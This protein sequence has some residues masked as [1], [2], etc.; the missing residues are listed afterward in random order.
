MLF[1]LCIGACYYLAGF[2]KYGRTVADVVILAAISLFIVALAYSTIVSFV[3]THGASAGASPWYMQALLVPV[4]ALIVRGLSRGGRIARALAC[5]DVVLWTYVIVATYVIKLLPQYGGYDLKLTHITDLAKW[6]AHSGIQRYE[7]L[8]TTTL[9]PPAILYGLLVAVGLFS[10]LT[11]T[12][13]CRMLLR[14]APTAS[15]QPVHQQ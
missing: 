15:S 14:A 12:A 4:M 8:Y 9:G 13:I 1:L 10:I 3:Y 11:S 6:Y 2:P 7:L 5:A